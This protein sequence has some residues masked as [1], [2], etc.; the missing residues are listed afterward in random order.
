MG[1][2]SDIVRRGTTG[3]VRAE[4]YHPYL[5]V[6]DNG[7]ERI[8]AIWTY[9][10]D[11]THLMT[12]YAW[13]LNSQI[14]HIRGVLLIKD[15]KMRMPTKE[16]ADKWEEVFHRSETDVAEWVLKYQPYQIVTELK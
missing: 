7:K 2:W 4:D 3:D 11:S 16:E 14:K 13:L 9:A 10:G 6:M 15:Y 12:Y 8:I 5:R 1:L